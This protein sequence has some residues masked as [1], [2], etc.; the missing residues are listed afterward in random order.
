MDYIQALVY[1][2]V[3]ERAA[4]RI[5]LAHNS[6]ISHRLLDRNTNCILILTSLFYFIPP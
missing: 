3:G 2:A 5:R 1:A 4:D 6:R